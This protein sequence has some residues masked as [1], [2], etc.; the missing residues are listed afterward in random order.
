MYP[1]KR[2][3]LPAVRALL[4]FVPPYGVRELDEPGSRGHLAS[5]VYAITGVAVSEALRCLHR[6]DLQVLVDSLNSLSQA[7]I[8]NLPWLFTATF[9]A[10]L[11]LVPL[12]GWIVSRARRRV[13]AT[14]TWALMICR[15]PA[16][17]R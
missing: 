5:G 14:S 17:C 10:T 8:E 2:G 9:V 4:D 6:G 3:L 7:G 12:F 11:L 15:C 13:I 16:A 1:S